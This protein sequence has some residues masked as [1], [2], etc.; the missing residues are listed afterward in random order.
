MGRGNIP[1]RLDR[2][3]QGISGA[4]HTSFLQVLR[5]V[6]TPVSALRAL[7]DDGRTYP[8]FELTGTGSDPLFMDGS[9]ELGAQ[10]RGSLVGNGWYL[11]KEEGMIKYETVRT[12]QP[13]SAGVLKEKGEEGW[14]LGGVTPNF[15]GKPLSPLVFYY[16][17]WKEEK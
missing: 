3:D 7:T 6:D 5:L 9:I 1:T 15:E 10:F 17:F 11:K 16:H 13:I 8:G 2:G 14:T 4:P 12:T